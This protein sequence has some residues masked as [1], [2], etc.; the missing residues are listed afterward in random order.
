LVVMIGLA[1]LT[2]CSSASDVASD[3]K[4]A[5]NDGV[6]TINETRTTSLHGKWRSSSGEERPASITV[7]Q[8]A[9][10][11]KLVVTLDG[12]VCLAESVVE[13]KVTIDGVKTTADV[14][15]M[16][17]ELEG[18]PGLEEV[19][20]NFEAIEDGP[21]PGQGGWLSVTR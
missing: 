20:G 3:A 14:A 12:H 9:L 16:H 2:G 17:L 5:T 15:G 13:A 11:A 1:G 4:G 8:R 18:E 19:I 6:E 7:E 21:C 10:T